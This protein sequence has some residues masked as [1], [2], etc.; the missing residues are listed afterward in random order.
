MFDEKG[1]CRTER[2][3]GKGRSEDGEIKWEGGKVK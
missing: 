1:R 2:E 3:G